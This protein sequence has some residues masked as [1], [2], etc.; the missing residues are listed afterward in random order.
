MK[1]KL[2]TPGVYSTDEPTEQLATKPYDD[3]SFVRIPCCP[4][5]KAEPA[6]IHAKK[7]KWIDEETLEGEAFCI[8]C[9][10]SIGILQVTMQTLFGLEEDNRVLNGRCRVY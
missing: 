8:H 10:K 7:S 6:D 9:K 5:C 1:I 3:A 2:L 4:S